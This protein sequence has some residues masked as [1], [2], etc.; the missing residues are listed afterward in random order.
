MD[1]T[2]DYEEYLLNTAC[3]DCLHLT[4]PRNEPVPF[5]QFATDAILHTDLMELCGGNGRPGEIGM[6][7]GLKVGPNMDINT[8]VNLNEPV[9]QRSALA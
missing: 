6:S 1:T 4:Q 8:G 2:G 3:T 5:H 9:E 7:C